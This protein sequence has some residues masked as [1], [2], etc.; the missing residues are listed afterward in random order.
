MGQRYPGFAASPPNSADGRARIDD[1]CIVVVAGSN[2]A[3]DPAVASFGSA[4][5]SAWPVTQSGRLTVLVG[6]DA[7]DAELLDGHLGSQP[8]KRVRGPA[9][10]LGDSIPRLAR[11]SADAVLAL[12]RPAAQHLFAD[13]L[14]VI[15]RGESRG[16]WSPALHG[17]TPDLELLGARVAVAQG[18]AI[19]VSDRRIG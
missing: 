6:E 2:Q 16:F 11:A 12:G 7:P 4:F 5:A 1:R 15:S 17:L 10:Y 13:L 19:W 18:L 3:L 8:C 14:I 9:D